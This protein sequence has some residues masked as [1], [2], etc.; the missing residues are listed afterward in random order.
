MMIVLNYVVSVP[1]LGAGGAVSML[2]SRAA[3]RPVARYEDVICV[4]DCASVRYETR[5]STIESLQVPRC[6][7]GRGTG[8]RRERPTA[9]G[10]DH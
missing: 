1:G 7:S 2:C 8:E 6:G 10:W 3:G 9:E 5:M 4:V